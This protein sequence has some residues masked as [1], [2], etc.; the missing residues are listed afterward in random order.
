MDWLI[1]GLG[2][3]GEQYQ[4]TRH[5]YGFLA[6][7]YLQEYYNA[8]NFEYNKYH[9]ADLSAVE[10]DDQQVC[11][12]KP[13]TFMNK[14]GESLI[15]FK[16]LIPNEQILVIYDDIDL[17]FQNL[18]IR[19]KGSAGTHNGLKSIINCLGSSNFPRIRC[20]IKPEHRINNMSQFVLAV[21]NKKE[22]RHLEE[23]FLDI[24]QATDLILRNELQEAAQK[25][26]KKC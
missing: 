9:R 18:R 25:F 7:D 26:N 16:Q 14:S 6:L 19:G 5:N 13:Q 11:L 17:P 10:I 20:G 23:L 24:G 4:W 3:P 21:F 22:R 1:V 2:N 15:K 12:L 8:P